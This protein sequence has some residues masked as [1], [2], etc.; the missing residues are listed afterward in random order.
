M[1]RA[2]RVYSI[3]VFFTMICSFCWA[4]GSENDGA[5]QKDSE[6][7]IDLPLKVGYSIPIGGDKFELENLEYAK[8]VG[9]DYVEVSGMG[10]F[11]GKDGEFKMSDEEIKKRL[12]WAKENADK[13]GIKIWSVHMPFGEH[14]DLSLVNEKDRSDVVAVQGK[15]TEF[16]EILEPKYLVYHPSWYLSL[17]E[18][19]RRKQQL[20]KSVEKLDEKAQNINATM[21]LENMLGPELL[22]NK[23][24]ERPL[25]RNIQE[26]EEMLARLPESVDIVID[27]NHIK[28]PEHLIETVG[29]RLK[30]LHVNDGTG[31]REDHYFPCSK[32]GKQAWDHIFSALEKVGYEGVFMYETTEYEDEKNLKSCYSSLYQSFKNEQ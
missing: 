19:G 20:I 10:T 5:G 3:F 30:S 11:V 9:V 14:I 25:M 24:Q 13:A 31:E 32:K 2:L 8:S 7:D 1:N 21:L 4:Y 23:D 22:K 26:V 18:R 17:D 12:Q 6:L 16:L 27:L 28:N 15:L 29:D